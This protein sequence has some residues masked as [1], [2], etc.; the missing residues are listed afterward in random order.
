METQYLWGLV[1]W[2]RKEQSKPRGELFHLQKLASLYVIGAMKNTLIVAL[3][4]LLQLQPLGLI[5][6]GRTRL[7]A[8]EIRLNGMAVPGAET[9]ISSTKP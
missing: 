8:H 4:L 9:K 3:E 1:W 5:I 6:K 7:T 2:P